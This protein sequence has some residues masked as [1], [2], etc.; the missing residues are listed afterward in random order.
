MKR[1]AP[2]SLALLNAA[3]RAAVLNHRLSQTRFA[4]RSPRFFS[5]KL[6]VSEKNEDSKKVEDF[7]SDTLTERLLFEFP[8]QLKIHLA[9]IILDIYVPGDT[10]KVVA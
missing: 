3:I 9:H 7:R 1:Q 10:T 8:R 2:K 6:D 4:P 5:E